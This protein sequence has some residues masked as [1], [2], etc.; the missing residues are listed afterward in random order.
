VKAL[1]TIGIAFSALKDRKLRS[2]LT[3]IGM[4]IGPATLV[5]LI[6]TTQG[7]NATLTDQFSQFG[8][9]TVVVTPQGAGEKLTLQDVAQ[10]ADV[11]HVS[12]AVPFYRTVATMKVGSKDIGAQVM[13]LDLSSLPL[14][15]PGLSV[16]E[17]VVPAS[18]DLTGSV[19]GYNLVQPPDPD[20]TPVSVNQLVSIQTTTRLFRENVAVTRSYL[21]EASLEKFGAGLLIDVDNGV[22]ISLEAGRTLTNAESLSG[23]FVKVD[24]IESVSA[25]V[26]GINDKLENV[27]VISVEQILNQIQTI[28]GGVSAFLVAIA[29]MSVAVAFIGITTTMFTS[30]T[31]RTREIGLFKALGYTRRSIMMIFIYEAGITGLIGGIAGAVAG[32][33]I[34]YTLVPMII[35][36]FSGSQAPEG[37]FQGGGGFAGG[38]SAPS[39]A[40]ELNPLITPDLILYAI[41]MALLVG[42][43]AGI[44]P[45]WRASRLTPVDALRHE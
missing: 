25:V 11:E 37:G 8:V 30:V 42:I 1:D 40:F 13:A 43:L 41:V 9:D 21:V 22:F 6:G 26:A 5:A 18:T 28:L 34:A 4:A 10:I 2:S 19:V 44:L 36:S 27:N 3:I 35:R 14:I 33:T 16:A 45:A 29:A 31:E 39:G 20:Q 12:A 17:G 23:V 24:D 32:G 7:F 38:G 15:L